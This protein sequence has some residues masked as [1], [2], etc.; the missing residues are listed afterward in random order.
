MD[1]TRKQHG[2]AYF[3]INSVGKPIY[4][5]ID[6]PATKEGQY[7]QIQ[8]SGF[9]HASFRAKENGK[10]LGGG[11]ICDFKARRLYDV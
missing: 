7:S 10:G 5:V 1:A 11:I 9:T 8:M 6:H 3:K 4:E 2:W